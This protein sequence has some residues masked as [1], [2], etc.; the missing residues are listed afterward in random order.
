MGL[1][2]AFHDTGNIFSNPEQYWD[3]VFKINGPATFSEWIARV[4]GKLFIVIILILSL[5]NFQDYVFRF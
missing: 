5:I 1:T 4:P 2:Q 3:K